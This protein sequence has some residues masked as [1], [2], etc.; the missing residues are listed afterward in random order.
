MSVNKNKKLS[1]IIKNKI[2]KKLLTISSAELLLNSHGLPNYL[3]ESNINDVNDNFNYSC[4]YCGVGDSR[5]TTRCGTKED[6]TPSQGCIKYS[7]SK[8]KTPSALPIHI[9]PSIKNSTSE[10]N[11]ISYKTAISK[12]ADQVLKH[13]NNDSQIL[14]YACGQ[15]DYFSIFAL[16]EVFRLLGVRN[17]T[18]N[19]E[20]CLNAGAVHNEILTGQEGPFVT[21]DSAL[22]GDNKFYIMNGWNGLVTHP[23]IFNKIINKSSFDG[24]LFDVMLTETG[25]SIINKKSENEVGLIK[26]GS[27]PLLALSVAHQILIKHSASVN[28]NLLIIGVT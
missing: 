6:M 7:Y 16:Q 13:M 18:G 27:D 9:E 23:P 2:S 8:M 17:L 1:E 20:H 14:I 4:S 24:V 10:R 15:I 21:I 3:L 22:S 26:S 25:Q 11:N 28:Q 19:A 5:T 12:L